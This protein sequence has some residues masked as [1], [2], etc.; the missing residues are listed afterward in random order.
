M[1]AIL[2]LS[3]TITGR[4]VGSEAATA[5]LSSGQVLWMVLPFLEVIQIFKTNYLSGNEDLY[6]TFHAL[7]ESSI[8]E[9]T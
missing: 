2:S 9:L 6:A 3:L 8:K 4:H 7:Q 5:N 1:S